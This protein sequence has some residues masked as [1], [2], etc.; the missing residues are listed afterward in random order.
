MVCPPVRGDK[1]RALASGL[2]P[3]QTYNLWL[4][5]GWYKGKIRQKPFGSHDFDAKHFLRHGYK[6]EHLGNMNVKQGIFEV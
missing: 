1:P 5:Q 3:V 2:F 6:V 4:G